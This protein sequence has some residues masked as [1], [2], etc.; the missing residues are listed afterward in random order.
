[1]PRLGD[2]DYHQGMRRIT[3]AAAIAAVMLSA[4]TVTEN[5]AIDGSGSV[6]SASEIHVEQFFVDV[7]ADFAEFLPDDNASI[8]DSAI[9]SFGNDLATRD[10]VLS[11][12][13]EKTGENEYRIDFSIEGI[14]DFLR[15]FGIEEQSLMT[16]TDNSFSF[17]LDIENYAELKE[18]VPFLADPN[19][20][21]Y[22]PEYNQ[23]MSEADYLEM[24]SFLLGEDGPGAI[25]NG[26]VTVR[27][28]VPGTI[29]ATENAEAVDSSTAEFSFPIISFLLLND[30]IS[31]SIGWE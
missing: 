25:E 11:A 27:I 21:V 3:L 26:L 4:C 28:S 22:G 9:E 15:G 14:E 8:M 31:F 2:I 29:T 17:H 30:P 20:E 24:L 6:T 10:A 5:I 12:A 7:L 23:G 1:M 16:L 13:T 19:F 18:I